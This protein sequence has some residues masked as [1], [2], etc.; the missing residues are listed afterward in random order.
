MRVGIIGL[1]VIVKNHI[2]AILAS[3][4]EIV[5][6]CDVDADR[7]ERAKER[8]NLPAAEAYTDY[9]LMLDTASLDAVHI[10]TPHHLHVTMACDALAR[11]IHVFC[12]KPMVISHRELNT[13]EAAVRR[14]SARL[15]V[16]QQ[17][18]CNPSSRYV[19]EL[20]GDRQVSAASAT[21]C[22]KRDRAYYDAEP[23]RGKWDTEGGGLMI[24]QALHTLDLLQWF[25]G[26]PVSVSAI[27]GNQS[28]FDVIQVEDTAFGRFKLANGGNFIIQATNA[29]SANFPI[30]I[31]LRVED[32]T[33]VIC[34]DTVTVNENVVNIKNEMPIL[35][36]AEY[37]TGHISLIAKF[38][39]CLQ[40]GEAFP[41][42][43]YEAAKVVRLILAMYES[44][45]QEIVL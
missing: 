45:G 10:C 29:S 24:N 8:F 43:F 6:L 1:G 35:G 26:Y 31:M 44:N 34:K 5:A 33:I 7:I 19:K 27:T 18:R 11:N 4:Q 28:L 13:L 36:K 3:G 38:Y 39:E 20:I 37:G 16:C 2:P 42:D 22:W 41:I 25:C 32:D 9:K 17:N 40:T 14:S 12:E 15:G 23:W 21:L 30:Q